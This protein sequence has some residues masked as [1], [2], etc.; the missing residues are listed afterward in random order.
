VTEPHA[1][2]PHWAELLLYRV[3]RV[4]L[5]TFSKTFWRA[6]FE[7]TENIPATGAFVLAPVHRSN[8]DTPILSGITTRR[9]HYMGKDSM[10]KVAWIG[11]L[12]T[13]LGSYPVHRGTADREALRKTTEIL[14]A[15]EPVV[16][17]PEGTRQ[18]GP[19]VQP[20]FEGAAY[21]ASKAGVPI[22]P[23]GIGGTE[24]AMPKGS[25]MLR[26]VRVRII[27]GEPILPPATDGGGRVP[28]RAVHELTEQLHARL[29]ELFDRAQARA[30]G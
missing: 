6:R 21:V 29:Q 28:R 12:F 24:A 7:G 5:L 11:R 15:G 19:L 14:E 10:W 4:L 3:V 30:A 22:V 25:K 13:A 1:K 17:F 9:L 26:P 16:I 23:V 20:L 18:S 27:V 2:K 8:V